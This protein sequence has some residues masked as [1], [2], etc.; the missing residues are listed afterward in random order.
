MREYALKGFAGA[1]AGICSYL[2]GGLDMALQ[3][4]VM[5][6]IIDI[7]TGTTKAFILKKIDAEESA[8][9]ILKKVMYFCLVAVAVRIDM[10]AG[11]NGS[12][13]L[14][15]IYSL[16]GTELYSITQNLIDINVIPENIAKYF[17]T[18]SEGLIHSEK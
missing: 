2:L 17:K 10:T 7:I 3:T 15:V 4:L 5:F 14:L 16:V 12:I 18:Y 11:A 8:K 13:R 9:G 1:V 6:V